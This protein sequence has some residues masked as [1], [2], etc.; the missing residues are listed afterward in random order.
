MVNILCVCKMNQARSILS[1]AI[2]KKFMPQANTY[3]AGIHAIS[4]ATPLNF[5]ILNGQK[6]GL[7]IPRKFSQN[8]RLF[9]LDK[10]D[11]ILV[12]EDHMKSYFTNAGIKVY[13]Y[14]DFCSFTDFIPIDPAGLAAEDAELELSKVFAATYKFVK[15]LKQ[16]K[17]KEIRLVIP[18]QELNIKNALD[19][20]VELSQRT[21]SVLID[22]DLRNSFRLD[23]ERAN[24][25]WM[26]IDETFISREIPT[27]SAVYLDLSSN[28]PEFEI[29]NGAYFAKIL[30]LAYLNE[31][32]I[33]SPPIYTNSKKLPD[34]ILLSAIA[35][36]IYS[37]G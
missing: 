34:S 32:T 10:F 4:D 35:D 16:D 18:R 7:N 36:E 29:A 8:L 19:F 23:F 15:H 24:F 25:N 26:R 33:L 12:A 21:G 2:V 37:L 14:Q 20:A 5:V 1:E 3:S 31:I 27:G 17:R 6:W 9:E 30:K 13:S 22:A 11:Y 28:I